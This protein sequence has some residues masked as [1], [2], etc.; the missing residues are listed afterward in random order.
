[1][2]QNDIVRDHLLSGQTINAKAALEEYG[3]RNLRARISELRL[4]SYAIGSR[5][6]SKMNGTK[7]REY[8]LLEADA[9][10]PEDDDLWGG[11]LHFTDS[12]LGETLCADETRWE[13]VCDGTAR[14]SV[15]GGWLYAVQGGATVFVPQPIA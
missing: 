6:S 9:P 14:L 3:I 5:V 15:P 13:Q 2:S 4:Q 8:F 1:M 7:H 11:E 12:D 10:V